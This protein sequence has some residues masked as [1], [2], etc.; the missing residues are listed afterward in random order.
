MGQT[1][2]V[3]VSAVRTAIGSFGGSLQNVSAT[4]LGGTVIKEA[5]NKVGVSANEV[6]EVIMGNVL[7]AG[8]GQ[9]PARQATLAA[10]LPETVSALTIN[11][12]CGSGL[13]AVHLATQA[14]LAGD[15][16]VIVAGGMENMSQAP[17]LLKNARNGF[18]MGDQKVV[19][20]MIQDGLW[21]AFND[22]HMGVTAENLCDKYEITRDEQDAFAASSQQKAEAAI[23]S[24]RFKDEIVPVEV[25]GRKGQVTIFEQDEFPRAGTT[26]ESLGKLRPAFKKDGS[27]TAGNASGINDGAAAVVV[28]SRKKADELGLTPLVSIK[29]NATAGVDPSIMGIGPVS[30]VKKALEKAAVSLEDVQLV[31]ANEAFAAQSIAVDRELQFNHDILNVNGGAIA[32]GHPIGASGTRVL[33]SLIHEMQ[34][35]DAKLGLAT[36]CIGGGQGVA[37]IVERP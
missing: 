11:K 15:A 34:K 33:V 20:S 14:I 24:G 18:K 3:I 29:A 7:Q 8:L 31:E 35:R 25:P 1:E 22:Y 12:V 4:T 26:A 16:D 2:V 36:L 30:A 19:D 37:T 32:L 27:V 6:D 5:L 28:M 23:Q 10:G 9:N 17:Y 21:C 13:K